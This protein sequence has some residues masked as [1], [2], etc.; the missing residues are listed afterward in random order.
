MSTQQQSVM[1][2]RA[3]R[4]QPTAAAPTDGGT[5]KIVMDLGKSVVIRGELC[6]LEDLTI[7][8]EMEGSITLPESMLTIG[9]HA[10]IKAEILARIVVVMGA[11]TGNVTAE[12]KVEIRATGSLAGDIFSPRVAIVD[13][14]CLRGRVQMP[15][16]DRIQPRLSSYRDS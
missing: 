9:P 13:G 16:S 4:E 15:P 11:V 12:E 14:G 8:G 7:D 3:R 10:D 2:L 6:G 5:Q 1:P